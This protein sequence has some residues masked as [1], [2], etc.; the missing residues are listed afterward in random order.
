MGSK[1]WKFMGS[2]VV[3][4]DSAERKT[5]RCKRVCG[6]TLIEMMLVIIIIGVLV[7]M[8]VPRLTGRS[9]QARIAAATADIEANLAVALDLYE[10]DNGG[11]PTGEQGLDALL[12]KPSI[13]PVP[14]NWNGPYLKRRLPKDPWGEP[15]IYRCPGLNNTYDYDLFSKGPDG[16]EGNADDIVN[17]SE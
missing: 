8:V 7:A 6:F 2:E 12:E 13:P 1:G 4:M 9:E 15:Y 10:L 11:Y 17:W 3:A 14:P 5:H 16:I